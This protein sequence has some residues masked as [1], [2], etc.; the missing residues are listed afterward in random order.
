M[1]ATTWRMTGIDTRGRDLEFSELRLY[2]STGG[3]V[4]S[5]IVTSSHLPRSGSLE[6][7][8]DGL[9]DGLCIFDAAT[10]AA[11]GF[12][13]QWVF[14]VAVNVLLARGVG[15]FHGYSLSFIQDGRWVLRAAPQ[16]WYQSGA[17]PFPEPGDALIDFVELTWDG[18]SP[19]RAIRATASKSDALWYFDG[20]AVNAP[21][22]RNFP[23]LLG[24]E[25]PVPMYMAGELGHS[26]RLV[27]SDSAALNPASTGGFCIEAWVFKDAAPSADSKY[28]FRAYSSAAGAADYN[29][30][31]VVATRLNT[32]AIYAVTGTGPGEASINTTTPLP[33]NEWVHLA[34]QI[35]ATHAKLY[36]NGVLLGSVAVSPYGVGIDTLA[37]GYDPGY[38]YR[39]W[40]GCISNLRITRGA[41]RY[42]ASFAVPTKPFALPYSGGVPFETD[43]VDPR[44]TPLEQAILGAAP[45]AQG[46]G[47]T[48]QLVAPQKLLDAEAGG[49]FCIYGSV[50]RN[51]TPA[52]LPLIR[53]V[54]LHRSRDGM[55]VR[56]VWSKADGS[57]EFT[58][59]SGRYEYDVIAWDHE[60]QFRSV[61]ANNLVPEVMP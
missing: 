30:G 4:E 54:R 38:A 31:V 37:I 18:A 28:V 13:I 43:P 29:K 10:V 44:T 47:D 19:R 12:Y 57:Y 58:E 24:R 21:A 22:K 41:V 35:D 26:L 42:P 46:M 5:A 7:L 23:I 14:P 27:F 39:A 25:Q 1:A 32:G 56:E 50:T 45:L 16:N 36:M 61:V 6:Q 52:N 9:H 53:R 33:L 34:L 59:I 51:E 17:G 48:S 55:L 49:N 15:T 3:V 20:P 11:P 60:L 2:D 40:E 8:A